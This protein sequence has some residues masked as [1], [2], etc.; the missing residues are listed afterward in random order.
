MGTRIRLLLSAL[1]LLAAGALLDAT[2]DT[3]QAQTTCQVAP[4]YDLF[5]NYYVG[6]PGVP[7]AM[8]VCPRPTPTFVGHTYITYQPLLPNEFL[9]RHTKVYRRYAGGVRPVNATMV[10]WW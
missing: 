4:Q 3:A 7:A 10:R 5:Y 2:A 6:P 9:Y 8:F 1:A